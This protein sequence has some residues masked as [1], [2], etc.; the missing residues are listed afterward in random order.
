MELKPYLD[1]YTGRAPLAIPYL[2]VEGADGS[3]QR[4]LLTRDLV[5]F[6]M[7]RRRAWELF[8]ELA[9]AAKPQSIPDNNASREDA[10]EAGA[11]EAIERV[12]AML[13]Q[14]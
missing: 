11:R 10:R 4:A 5:N 12:I 6:C 2:W 3:P 7:D 13:A 8:E 1:A 9:G 14:G